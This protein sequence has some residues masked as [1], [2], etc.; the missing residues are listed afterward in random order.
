MGKSPKPP[1]VGPEWDYPVDLVRLWAAVTL[2]EKDPT[3]L[4]VPRGAFGQVCLELSRLRKLQG[5]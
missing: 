3:H 1:V 2:Y 4:L 5:L